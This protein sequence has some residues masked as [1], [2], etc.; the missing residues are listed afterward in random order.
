[1]HSWEDYFGCLF[2]NLWSNEGNKHQHNTP[3]NIWTVY[4]QRTYIILFLT[5]HYEYINGNK[6]EDLHN[7]ISFLIHLVYI[8][9]MMSQLIAYDDTNAL[10]DAIVTY[11][12]E[13]QYLT[14][15]ISILFM[16]I[17][18]PGSIRNLT[19]TSSCAQLYL[20]QWYLINF[21]KFLVTGIPFVFQQVAQ[22]YNKGTS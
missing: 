18:T 12:S 9:L 20:L 17:F 19:I 3:V 13:N 10:H 22:L 11:A 14:C 6:R 1:M 8:V 5:C 16:A 4:H 2:S 7:S 15:L 21:M